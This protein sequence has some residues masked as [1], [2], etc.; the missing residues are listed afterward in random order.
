LDDF[1]VA[2]DPIGDNRLRNQRTVRERNAQHGTDVSFG[3]V[4]KGWIA[5]FNRW[6][7]KRWLGK[8]VVVVQIER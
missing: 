8:S 4:L 7:G 2:C 6:I 3:A 1:N 5:L